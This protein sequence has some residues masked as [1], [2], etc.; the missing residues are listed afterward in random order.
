MFSVVDVG[1]A[2]FLVKRHQKQTLIAYRRN[3]NLRAKMGIEWMTRSFCSF[4][5]E[6]VHLKEF[7]ARS[8]A[9]T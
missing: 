7:R 1:V 4:C 2:I 8:H 3:A 6:V 5:F 9:H